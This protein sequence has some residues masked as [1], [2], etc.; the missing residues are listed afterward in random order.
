MSDEN[1]LIIADES[2]T[3]SDE[4]HAVLV[5]FAKTHPELGAN[6]T[7]FEFRI[8]DPVAFWAAINEFT[9][10]ARKALQPLIDVLTRINEQVNEPY[11]SEYGMTMSE[12]MALQEYFEGQQWDVDW[13]EE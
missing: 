12:Y 3:V 8:A 6:V 7:S 4:Q 11:L 10:N 9:D 1:P 5:E 13:K 2:F